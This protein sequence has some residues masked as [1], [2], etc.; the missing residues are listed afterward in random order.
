MKKIILVV[1]D[2]FGIRNKEVGNAIKQADTPVID[3][4]LSE[5]P[6]T[7]LEASGPSVG[8][9]KGQ[10]GNS[11]VGHITLG[12]GRITK[13][14]LVLINDEIKTKSFFSNKNLLNVIEHVNK[15]ESSLHV[16]GLLSNGGVHSSINHFYAVLALAK[17]K[18]IKKLYF[19]IFTDGR[20][21]S[22]TSGKGF[23]SDLEEKIAKLNLGEIASVCG[24]YYA[25]DRDNKWDRTKKAYDLITT[26]F[27]NSF[28]SA[29]GCLEK[30]YKNGVTDEFINPSLI[31][32]KGI[33]NNN[34]GIIFI[35]FRNERMKQLLD[36]FVKDD[37]NLFKPKKFENLSICS[38]YN[39]HENVAYAFDTN[40]LKNVFGEYIDNLDFSQARV[41]ETEKYAHVTHFFDGGEDL[42]LKNCDKF[43]IPSP[44]VATY[45]MKPEMSA[46]LITEEV[47]KLL[48]DEYDFILINFAN[49]DMV[50]HTGNFKAAIEA[51]EIV[52]FCLG[53]IVEAAEA[54]FY[55]MVITADHG[56]AEEM[57]D[58]EANVVTSHTTNKVPFIILDKN[59]KL[60]SEGTIAD[61]IPTLIDIYE[62]KK[63]K[64]MT[65]ESLI[66]K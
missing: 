5:Y 6:N 7:L 35:N 42:E 44:N 33:I 46:A 20:D 19:H 49:T 17:L 64:E 26:G 10:C 12:S 58:D 53:K 54:N 60:K 51:T 4:L 16:V 45:D 59:I 56:N 41:A 37:F 65:G 55:D 31:K 9:P 13:Q 25:M 39:I 15:N 48:D 61:V 40:K 28:R 8:L 63:P 50:G 34:D 11:E 57:L 24:R 14:P 1:L 18:K 52:D 27:G 29:A 2:G 23:V 21:T 3:R 32:Q 22:P 30:H 38:L 43:L 36:A 66:E 62:V 47:L